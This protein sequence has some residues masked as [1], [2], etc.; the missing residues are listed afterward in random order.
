MLKDGRETS[1]RWQPQ[2]IY[3]R[4]GGRRVDA[5]MRQI[6]FAVKKKKKRTSLQ[7]LSDQRMEAESSAKLP[8]TLI[9]PLKSP[10]NNT[11]RNSTDPN[12]D[13]FKWCAELNL[14]TYMGCHGRSL[15]ALPLPTSLMGLQLATRMCVPASHLGL[16]GRCPAAVKRKQMD[17]KNRGPKITRTSESEEFYFKSV[18]LKKCDDIVW[19]FSLYINLALSWN[20]KKKIPQ[21]I[22]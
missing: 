8:Q 17:G 20:G 18:K 16:L 12:P 3:G 21:N 14:P 15:R 11:C 6:I 9:F 1:S 5:Q 7:G 10:R 2:G 22:K 4:G 19:I 13:S